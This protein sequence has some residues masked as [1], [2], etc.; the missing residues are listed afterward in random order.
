MSTETSLPTDAVRRFGLLFPD[1]FDLQYE[2]SD[3][4]ACWER[5][6]SLSPSEFTVLKQKRNDATHPADPVTLMW[7][8][9]APSKEKAATVLGPDGQPAWDQEKVL[10]YMD[11]ES[12]SRSISLRLGD[13][14]ATHVGLLATAGLLGHALEKTIETIGEHAIHAGIDGHWVPVALTAAVAVVKAHDIKEACETYMSFKESWTDRP[15]EVTQKRWKIA[16]WKNTSN[17][18]HPLRAF[19]ALAPRPTA[20]KD[21]HQRQLRLPHELSKRLATCPLTQQAAA[22][23]APTKAHFI[24]DRYEQPGIRQQAAEMGARVAAKLYQLTVLITGNDP[25]ASLRVAPSDES[26]P[27][28]ARTLDEAAA[29]TRAPT[30]VA[31]GPSRKTSSS[32]RV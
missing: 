26:P 31:L 32:L 15:G 9:C 24:A 21:I 19:D 18:H 22:L 25:R 3:L 7:Y 2:E 14:L 30:L 23:L 10:S 6:E 12:G 1:G 5:L 20:W 27:R 16:P 13:A 8:L 11:D 4:D 28:Q 17:P 29:P